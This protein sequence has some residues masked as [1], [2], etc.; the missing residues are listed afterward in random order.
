MLGSGI[1]GGICWCIVKLEV[2]DGSSGNDAAG[3][4]DKED[5]NSDWLCIWEWACEAWAVTCARACWCD[6]PKGAY[7]YHKLEKQ[8]AENK[9][10]LFF[11]IFL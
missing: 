11:F 8:I 5:G 9:F 1:E 6:I 2:N 10:Q 3:A 4:A 7:V